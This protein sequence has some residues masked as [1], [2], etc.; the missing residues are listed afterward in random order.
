MINFGKY[1]QKVSFV[2]FGQVSDG[3]GGYVPSETVAL[4][5]FASVKQVRASGDI[6]Q[7]QLTLPNTYSIY[8]QQRN[9]FTPNT[10][11]SIKYRNEILKVNSFEQTTERGALEWKF[12]AVKS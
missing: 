6:E 8:I 10:M 5:T 4:S 3:Y 1:D 7:A 9:G 2:T 12:I 11:L